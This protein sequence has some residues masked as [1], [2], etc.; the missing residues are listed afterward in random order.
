MATPTPTPLHSPLEIKVLLHHYYSPRNWTAENPDSKEAGEAT[1]YWLAE[2]CLM[3]VDGTDRESGMQLTIRGLKTVEAWMNLPLPPRPIK[4]VPPAPQ[5]VIDA[6]IVVRDKHPEI[7]RVIFCRDGTWEY[8]DS[9]TGAW[10]GGWLVSNPNA[11]QAAADAAAER[12][13]LP[14][15]FEVID[16][17]EEEQSWP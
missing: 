15:I 1:D 5:A 10:E 11:L 17:I 7:D 2:G 9:S 3:E 12:C 14:C 13:T 4:V 8:S 16:Q 6:L